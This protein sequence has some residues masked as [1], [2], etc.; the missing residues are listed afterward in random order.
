MYVHMY[1]WE[2]REEGMGES[3]GGKGILMKVE[4]I[5]SSSIDVKIY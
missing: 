1:V 4:A 3:K 5:H 2:G